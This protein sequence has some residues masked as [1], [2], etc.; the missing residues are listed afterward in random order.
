MIYVT[1]SVIVPRRPEVVWG[2]L[3]DVTRLTV[4]VEA[5]VKADLATDR[6]AGVGM[7]LDLVHATKRGRTVATSEVTAWREPE[8]L[9][10]ETRYGDALLFDR[11][12]LAPVV[13]APEGTGAG[14]GTELV[15]ESEFMLGSKVAEIFGRPYGLFGAEDRNPFQPIYERSLAALARMIEAETL[16]PYR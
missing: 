11:A 15:V 10:V 4:W 9:C 7:T 8:F 2:F 5:L 6:R 13:V 14:T 3:T 1:T 12:R 16:R